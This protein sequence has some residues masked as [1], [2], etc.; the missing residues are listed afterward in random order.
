MD[1]DETVKKIFLLTFLIYQLCFNQFLDILKYYR[2]KLL[3]WV[4]K[5]KNQYGFSH[6]R[7][8]VALDKM[9]S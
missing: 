6:L 7:L 2:Q 1:L 8:N 3:Q 4:T 9:Q 5:T